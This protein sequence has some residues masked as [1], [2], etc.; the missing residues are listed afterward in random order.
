MRIQSKNAYQAFIHTK[1]VPL[2]GASTSQAGKFNQHQPLDLLTTLNQWQAE[3]NDD[4]R[5]AARWPR[6]KM[7]L[8]VHIETRP[9][10]PELDKIILQAMRQW[11]TASIGLIRFAPANP[12]SNRD[13]DADIIVTWRSDTV[14]GRDYETGHTDRKL[15]GQ[16][17]TQAIITLIENPLIDAHLTP[18][19]QINRLYATIL[20]ETG[21]ALG[22]EH[23]TD[24]KDVMHYR[25]WQRPYLSAN[26]TRRIQVLY[27]PL[28]QLRF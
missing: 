15:Q 6:D 17:I 25:G 10:K 9:G 4:T 27:Q 12:L 11:E 8:Q 1:G 13:T 19:R 3:A 22:L 26:D 21:H 20:H 24:A 14:T 7:P 18:E 5:T 28:D 16:R 23:S 2:G